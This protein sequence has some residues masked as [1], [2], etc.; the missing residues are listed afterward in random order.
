[1]CDCVF[2]ACVREY[3]CV[4]VSV[5]CSIFST[6]DSKTVPEVQEKSEEIIFFKEIGFQNM[7]SN[8]SCFSR[9]VII[10]NDMH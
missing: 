6:R 7:A 2:F 8:R 5:F 9:L 3:V 10:E 1:M 4:C